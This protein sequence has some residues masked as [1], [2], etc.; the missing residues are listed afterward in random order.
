MFSLPTLVYLGFVFIYINQS[1]ER[2]HDKFVLYT[3][4]KRPSLRVVLAQ[5]S[6]QSNYK[7]LSQLCNLTPNLQSIFKVNQCWL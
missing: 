5:Y 1:S 7:V 4:D 6:F 3:P 2:K